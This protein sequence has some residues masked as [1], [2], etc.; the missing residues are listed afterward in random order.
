MPSSSSVCSLQPRKA[1]FWLVVAA[2]P[3][4][5]ACSCMGRLAATSDLSPAASPPTTSLCCSIDRS[6]IRALLLVTFRVFC[7][8]K[9]GGCLPRSR[10]CGTHLFSAGLSPT[11][12]CA[13]PRHL[14]RAF[15][16]VGV[17]ILAALR[18]PRCCC[19]CRSCCACTCG[20]VPLAA[21][22]GCT[23]TGASARTLGFACHLGAAPRLADEAGTME[24]TELRTTPPRFGPGL[25]SSSSSSSGTSS[26]GP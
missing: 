1:S 20:R 6:A 13:S 9:Q 14:L 8:E 19:G 4:A 23:R 15:L 16:R 24:L 25:T 21:L 10:N 17:C 11:L 2:K 22:L 5:E 18:S 26:I 7:G 12:L 3:P